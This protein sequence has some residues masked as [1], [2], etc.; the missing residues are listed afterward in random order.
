MRTLARLAGL[1]HSTLSHWS[2]T[3]NTPDRATLERIAAL[4]EAP[5]PP[6]MAAWMVTGVGSPP[7]ANDPSPDGAPPRGPGS[8]PSAL[9]ISPAQPIGHVVELL[10]AVWRHRVSVDEAA[11]ALGVLMRASITAAESRRIPCS[12][13]PQPAAAS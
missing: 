12:S 5:D 3:G 7:S 10:E 13:S 11:G 1:S 8:G 6:R 2:T 4:V 9:P